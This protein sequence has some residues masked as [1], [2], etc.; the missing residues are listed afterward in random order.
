MKP[1]TFA[2]FEQYSAALHHTGFRA[3]SLG[4]QRRP[5]TLSHVQ[6]DEVSVQWGEDGGAIVFEGASDGAGILFFMGPNADGKLSGN[7]VRL[8]EGAVMLI[9]PRIEICTVALD[10]TRWLSAFVPFRALGDMSATTGAWDRRSCMI[11]QPITSLARCVRATLVAIMNAAEADA[12]DSDSRAGTAAANVLL[13]QTRALVGAAELPDDAHMHGRHRI[14][15][16]EIIRRATRLLDDHVGEPVSLDELAATTGVSLRTLNSAFREQFG[17]S[18]KRYLRLRTLN[19]AHRDLQTAD[20]NTTRVTDV[21]TRL[22]IWE[23]GRF[24][25]DY[26]ALFGEL[27]SQTLHRTN[28]CFS[29]PLHPARFKP[30]TRRRRTPPRAC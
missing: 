16:A 26:H 22:G 15:R 23:F 28:R 6:L 5:Y 14:P 12:F 3:T 24:S 1:H 17:I 10:T 21:A 9:P 13:E 25:H 11:M 30:I 27:P 2:S 29:S 8:N 7:G 18:P 20:R 19:Q 4:P